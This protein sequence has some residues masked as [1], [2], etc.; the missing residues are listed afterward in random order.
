M[1]KNWFFRDNQLTLLFA[2]SL[3]SGLL[4]SSGLFESKFND[5]IPPLLNR[6]L[7]LG[8]PKKL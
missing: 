8:K 6:F 5:I 4:R 7:F 2:L 3:L 1:A